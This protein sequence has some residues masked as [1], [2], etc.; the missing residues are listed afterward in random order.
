MRQRLPIAISLAA[1]VVAVLG[2][3]SLGEAAR[4]GVTSGV[5][6]AKQAAGLGAERQAVRR[7]PRGPR[8][9]RG[10]RG[11]RGYR[12][13]LGS[14]GENGAKG[15]KGDKGDRG[16]IGLSKVYEGG[17]CFQV[18]LMDCGGL[19]PIFVSWETWGEGTPFI[20]TIPNLP[21]GSYTVNAVVEVTAGSSAGWWVECLLR[22]P[23]TGDNVF[24]GGHSGA[25][26]GNTAGH[27]GLVSMPIT[28]GATITSTSTL[29]LKCFRTNGS[30][31][32]PQ[33]LYVHITATTVGSRNW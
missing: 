30:G 4:N 8:G 19:P 15:D 5:S 31:L 7:G 29:G 17:Y 18:F 14:P 12:G 10:R 9:P 22:V 26:V 25:W 2:S 20:V 3:T 16:P 27:V 33:V 1:L 32:D 6:K 24:S 11:P 21:A 23:L 13:F 28:F